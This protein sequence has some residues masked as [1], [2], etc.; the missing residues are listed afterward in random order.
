MAAHSSGC[1]FLYP[2]QSAAS[3]EAVLRQQ[4]GQYEV[5][6]HL[7]TVIKER[8]AAVMSKDRGVNSGECLVSGGLTR[9]LCYINRFISLPY[10]RENLPLPPPS[11]P[12]QHLTIPLDKFN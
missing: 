9:A 2:D 1:S 12:E 5:F 7:E 4:D 3:S 10:F 6:Y 8:V 11:S